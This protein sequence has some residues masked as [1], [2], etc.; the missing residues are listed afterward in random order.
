MK[1]VGKISPINFI[2]QAEAQKFITL[3]KARLAKEPARG[4]KQPT[5]TKTTTLK[6]VEYIQESKLKQQSRLNQL[7]PK[8]L[9]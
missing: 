4:E 7:Q 9:H 2:M 3:S 8:Q 1:R 6:A 5:P